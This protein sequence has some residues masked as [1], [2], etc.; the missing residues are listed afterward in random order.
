M[1]GARAAVVIPCFN[2]GRYL[3]EAV[4]SALDQTVT[5]VEI[6]IVDDG[7]TDPDTRT[8]LDGYAR[9]R[10]RVLRTTNR[11]LP[12]AK[13]AGIAATSAQYVCALDADDR[14]AP[15]MIERSMAVLD[16][17]PD[18]AFVSHWLRTFGEEEAEWTPERCDLPAL[19]DLNTVNG[20]ALVR[21]AAVDAVGGYDES[22]RDGCEDWDF[23]ITL[24]ERGYL[25]TILPEVLF[26]YR[27]RPDSMSRRMHRE[28]G[29][30]RLFRRLI[31][32][33]A[34]AYGRHVGPLLARRERDLASTSAHTRE[35]DALSVWMRAELAGRCDDLV[36]LQRA[37]TEPWRARL[38][39]LTAERDRAVF[40][41]AALR[42][43]WSWRV[44]APLRASLDTI[45]W[46][47]GTR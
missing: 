9:P 42:R 29:H 19:L 6:V 28:S 21:R 20:A 14:L 43:S 32:K 17:Q 11:G 37:R 36:M 25:G 35:L 10:T 18:L 7:S 15:T 1:T 4:Q 13:N 5:D 39:E 40:E 34:D 24:V 3:D 41:V 30:V 27:R 12:A 2:L 31:E 23:W 38:A 16:E 33:H 47:R 45:R 44:T 46:L 22:F 26:H 8:L